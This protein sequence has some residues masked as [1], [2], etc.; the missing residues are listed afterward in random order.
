MRLRNKL[1]AAV[2]RRF[3]THS[4]I[5]VNR[6]LYVIFVF[7][8]QINENIKSTLLSFTIQKYI[9]FTYDRY[10]QL[11]SSQI[12]EGKPHFA[13]FGSSDVNQKRQ[14]HLRSIQ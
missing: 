3:L 12:E 7:I 1:L 11:L 5:L 14:K 2:G 4:L 6:E 8:N 9:N 13:D 10:N